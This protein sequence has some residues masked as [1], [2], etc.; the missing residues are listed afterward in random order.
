[1]VGTGAIAVVLVTALPALALSTAILP[2]IV[3]HLLVDRSPR[4]QSWVVAGAALLLGAALV[5]PAL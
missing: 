1:M 2:R 4:A 3:G 5:L